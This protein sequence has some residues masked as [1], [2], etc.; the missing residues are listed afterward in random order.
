MLSVLLAC[1]GHIIFRYENCL[2]G[3]LHYRTAFLVITFNLIQ[4]KHIQ[5]S[6][7]HNLGFTFRHFSEQ[8]KKVTFKCLE[9]IKETKIQDIIQC[10]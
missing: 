9:V 6:N 2:F 8:N 4:S 10:F 5:K 3:R 1:C 7:N